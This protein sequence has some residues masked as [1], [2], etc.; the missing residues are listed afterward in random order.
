MLVIFDN[1]YHTVKEEN[2][3]GILRLEVHSIDR[4]TIRCDSNKIRL[5]DNLVVHKDSTL[6][7]MEDR[8][9]MRQ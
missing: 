4:S 2:S 5:V 3:A 6:E 8:R 1:D 9:D 7:A